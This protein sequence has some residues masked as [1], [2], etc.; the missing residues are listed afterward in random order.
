MVTAPREVEIPVR[1]FFYTLDQIAHMLNCTETSLRGKLYY[2][3]R[4]NAPRVSYKMV[5]VN[6]A[7]PEQRPEWRIEETEFFRWLKV[8]GYVRPKTGLLKR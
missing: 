7:M 5:A 4:S 8:M 2:T 3:G 1:P 6:V